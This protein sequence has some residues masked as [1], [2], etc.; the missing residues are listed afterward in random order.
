MI[1]SLIKSALFNVSGTQPSIKFLT[2]PYK[3]CYST[4]TSSFFKLRPYQEDCIQASL[5]A[6]AS[7]INSQAVSLPVGAGKTVIFSNLLKRIP[8]P[9]GGASKTLILAHREELIKQAARQ[10]SIIAP[11]LVRIIMLYCNE[12]SNL[13]IYLVLL[14]V[15]C[16]L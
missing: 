2:L 13:L 3:Y 11:D 9:F 15:V 14:F 4:V 8:D 5:S 6:F 10:L 16:V 1:P 7:G 12:L